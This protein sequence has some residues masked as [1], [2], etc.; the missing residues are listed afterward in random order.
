MIGDLWSRLTEEEAK[1]VQQFVTE[2]PV[3]VGELAEKLGLAVIR[4]PMAPKVSGLIQP[5][6]RAASG[7][8]IRVNKFEVPERQRFTV[9][10]E[11]AHYLL[12]RDH[13]G[14]GVVDNVLYRSNLTSKKE[15]EANRFAADI[16]MPVN[17]VVDELKRLGGSRT[18]DTA[19]ELANLFRVSLPAMRVRLGLT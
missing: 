18:E 15:T 12:H 14:S 13:I 9:A 3:R 10:H 19:Q 7:F 16:I 1:I 11:I 6:E 2:R 5:S 17:L 4:S 8:E